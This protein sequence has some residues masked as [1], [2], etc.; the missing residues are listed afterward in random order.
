[1]IQY[2]HTLRSGELR[3]STIHSAR[4]YHASPHAE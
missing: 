3:V 1:M 2:V 4:T